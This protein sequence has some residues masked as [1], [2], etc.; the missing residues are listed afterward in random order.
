MNERYTD[1]PLL[2]GLAIDPYYGGSHRDFLDRLAKLSRHQWKLSTGQA[3]FWKWRMRSFPLH[4][5]DEQLHL[6]K[7]GN[8]AT[9][10]HHQHKQADRAP[11]SAHVSP[12]SLSQQSIPDGIIVTSMLD[13]TSY[14]GFLA[15]KFADHLTSQLVRDQCLELLR[16]PTAIY[17]H[18]NQL[19]YPISPHAKNDA[20]YG[21]TNITSALVAN[22]IW[23]NS[24]FHRADFLEQAKSFISRMPDCRHVHN[25]DDL[26]GKSSVLP[27]GFNWVGNTPTSENPNP[28][29]PSLGDSNFPPITIGWVARWEYDK[30]PDRFRELL[31][32]LDHHAVPFELV[33]L[34]PRGKQ[35]DSLAKIESMYKDRIK[36]TG[37]ADS[38]AK[39]QQA[40]RQ[41]DF[42]VSTA[43][44]EFFGIGICEAISAGAVPILPSKLSYPELAPAC[45]LYDSLDDAVAKIKRY[46]DPSTRHTLSEKCQERV[47]QFRAEACIAKIDDA[48]E[49]MVRQANVNHSSR[50]K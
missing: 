4:L 3:R 2:S 30:R 12:T 48:Y 28:I 31:G 8:G 26:E 50:G 34:G 17:F 18:E 45:C 49:Q 5:V 16:R 14:R 46:R 1:E 7:D 33:L 25:L 36:I 41:I 10:S 38:I 35:Q 39:Y 9:P 6:V 13:L 42:V 20:H 27:P 15:S 23:F 19:S 44:H 43:D 47:M 32:M 40:L 29:H 37:H 24:E 22:E 21:Y 11:Q